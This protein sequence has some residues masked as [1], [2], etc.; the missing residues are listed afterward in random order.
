MKIPPN[1]RRLFRY[2]VVGVSTFALDLGMLF[3]AT[4]IFGVPYFVAT[5]ISFLIAV[6]I[7]YAINREVTFSDTKRPWRAGYVYFVGGALVGATATTFLVTF[8][9]SSLGLF[10]LTA[11]VITSFI[12][13]IGNYFFNLYV[14][15]KVAGTYPKKP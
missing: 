11:R 14:N 3:T 1:V 4:S 12:V 13:G 7:N 5:P 9:V 10:Y 6:S 15:F 2:M 8:F